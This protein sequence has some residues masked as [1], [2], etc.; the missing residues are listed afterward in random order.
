ML[1]SK[2]GGQKADDPQ[3]T[4][5]KYKKTKLFCVLVIC[6]VGYFTS[7]EENDVHK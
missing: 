2:I 1:Q 7:A 5:A 3:D 4:H 6:F